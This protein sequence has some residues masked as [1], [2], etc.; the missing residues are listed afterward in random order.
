MLS[1]PFCCGIVGAYAFHFVVFFFL[2]VLQSDSRHPR[3]GLLTVSNS[4]GVTSP[5]PMLP[6]CVPGS[7]LRGDK[8][9]VASS[10][11]C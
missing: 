6:Q 2:L 10:I 8:S 11:C 9:I 5:I 1:D 4:S 3:P 7:Q